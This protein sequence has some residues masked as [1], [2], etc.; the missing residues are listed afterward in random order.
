M[1]RPGSRPHFGRIARA[2]RT[3]LAIAITV[4]LAARAAPAGTIVG[5]AD[6]TS[7]PAVTA[8]PTVATTANGPVTFVAGGARPVTVRRPA[9][10]SPDAP[11]PLLLLLHGYGSSG[12]GIEEYLH[13]GAEALARGMVVAAPDGTEDYDGSRFWNATDACCG[14]IESGIDDSG[15]LADLIAEISRTTAI[16]PARVY[17]AGHSNGGYMSHRMACDHADVIAAIV[18]IAGVTFADPDRCQPT[19]PVAVLQIHGTADE[20]VP[21]LGDPPG[22]RGGPGAAATAKMWA[23]YDGCDAEGVVQP[24]HL[25]LVNGLSDASG[26]TE[27][28]VTVFDQGCRP[29][30]HVELWTME[31]AVHGPMFS[32]ALAPAVIDFLLAHPKPA[33]P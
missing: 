8:S 20:Q 30:G 11:A 17:V 4:T 12:T 22:I 7:P 6:V 25:D 28:T 29:W 21:Y 14:P 31:G 27:T 2:R 33:T 32:E 23:A 3:G 13:L 24:D 19:E 5:S 9:D 16:D 18:S 26:P 15:Y 1:D 10:L